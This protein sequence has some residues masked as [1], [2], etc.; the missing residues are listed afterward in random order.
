MSASGEAVNDGAKVP[1]KKRL[2][3][4]SL[5]VQVFIALG[6]GLLAGI[7]FGELML[8]L[9]P[10]GDIFIGLLQMAVWP[11]IVV[12][13]IGGL[14]RLT[15]TQAASLGVRGG[16][17]LLLFWGIALLFV[18]AFVATFPSWTSAA[19]FTTSLAEPASA[20]DFV[21]LYVPSN[22]FASLANSV[23]PAVVLFSIAMG[24]ALI[25]LDQQKKQPVLDLLETLTSAFMSIAS[26]VVRLAPLG[27]LALVGV[28][29]GTMRADEL[30]RLQVYIY[31][32]ISITLLLSLWV[33]PG[34]VTVIMPISYRQL[35]SAA[36]K[37]LITV[38]A[39]GSLLVALP[40]IAEA[41][42]KVLTDMGSRSRDSLSAIDV[43]V[44]VNFT[45]PNVGK[46]IALAFVPFA[47][48]LTGFEMSTGQYPVFL[49]SGLFSMFAEVIA[50]PFLLDLTRIP[51]DTF[52]LFVALDVSTG[53]FGQLLGGVHTFALA[54]LVAAAVSGLLKVRRAA[55]IRYLLITVSLTVVVLGGLRLC[56]EYVL[57]H[58][59]E[60]DTRFKSMQ[61]AATTIPVIRSVFETQAAG[62]PIAGYSKLDQIIEQKVLRVGYIEDSLPSVF[63]NSDSEL[64]G[65]DVD[66]AIVLAR[67]IGVALEF[68]EVPPDSM[69]DCLDLGLC[70][71]VM[72]GLTI[73]P[74]RMLGMRFSDPYMKATGSFVVRD[75]HRSKFS[76]REA[77]QTL[78]APRIGVLDDPYYVN[79]LQTY[80]PRAEIV[81]FD[82]VDD[83]FESP[84]DELD[85]MF[86][87]AERGSAFT[88]V[89][90]EFS[91]AIPQPD[92]LAAPV[93]IAM[94][95][96]A[97]KFETFINA[98]LQLKREDQTI[99]QL[100]RYWVLGGGAEPRQPRWSV[101][102]DVLGWI[103]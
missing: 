16:A 4:P 78:S 25:P 42:K 92:V 76:S 50:L 7:F 87:S 96:D 70:D 58:D 18:L 28:A 44:P 8:V 68:V 11:Y 17:F 61:S 91:V 49:F 95:S 99:D 22:P 97:E 90:P 67:E 82:S 62:D 15:P 41:A 20:F 14:G 77:V 37:A 33:L 64:V 39:T 24:F 75:H 102:R 32:Y 30:V 103:E 38:F 73:T 19:F 53:R 81:L 6:V 100:Y 88:L 80:L 29:A 34:L 2:R 9:E 35:M 52:Q 83:F 101:I 98:W 5:S 1:P 21:G 36:Q 72:S 27:V 85:A 60:Q 48:W 63:L 26:F 51:S 66:L 65:M 12:S 69:S 56:Y 86:M 74:D 54:V 59:Y 40:L 55:L 94:H 57:P 89:H 43:T 45:L 46:L 3:M 71:L 31:S 10:V 93:S 13:L 23:L 79:T 47:G 84:S